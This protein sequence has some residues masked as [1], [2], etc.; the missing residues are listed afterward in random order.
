MGLEQSLSSIRKKI[1]EF[2]TW[3]NTAKG[4]LDLIATHIENSTIKEGTTVTYPQG[5]TPPPPRSGLQQ[6][7]LDNVG[8]MKTQVESMNLSATGLINSARE[9]CDQ[10]G[11][12]ASIRADL[13]Q[14]EAVGKELTA[15]EGQVEFGQLQAEQI[16]K[17]LDADAYR[18][19][20]TSQRGAIDA[21]QWA[22]T[23][24]GRGCE[25]AALKGENFYVAVDAALDEIPKGRICPGGDPT[26]AALPNKFDFDVVHPGRIRSASNAL[27]TAM[28][29]LET[30]FERAFQYLPPRKPGPQMPDEDRWVSVTDRVRAPWPKVN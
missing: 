23:G 11:W 12:L 15:A 13:T 30:A 9:L 7:F 8:S 21:A 3:H 5:S 16:W 14:W 20:V 19:H 10:S 6:T 17:G 2:E 26:C 24:L 18:R 28:T 1:T 25:S 22:V 27:T 4:D 29:T